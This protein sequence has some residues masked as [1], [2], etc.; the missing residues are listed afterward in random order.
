MSFAK[1][2]AQILDSSLAEDYRVRLVFEDMLKLS[3]AKGVVDMTRESIARRTN[4]PLK[5]V[6][7]S[8]KTLEDP[9]PT[10]RTPDYDGR[11][12]VRL[13]A[14]RDWG[15]RIVNFVKYR[16]SAT[17]E[18]LR[19]AEAERKKA[20]RSRHSRKPSSPI[21]PT[22][23]GTEAEGEADKSM[24]MSGTCPGHASGNGKLSTPQLIAL[25]GQVRRKSAR[26]HELQKQAPFEK[27][28]PR[29]S[30]FKQL[31]FEIPQLEKQLTRATA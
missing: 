12:I 16:E 27:Q 31:K 13:D 6:S 22:P 9:D 18:M 23:T 3:D 28:D 14:H 15:W 5:I 17:V 29:L 25:D 21:P 19:M 10:S 8:I 1:V 7:D 4:V 11:R 24:D 20:Y 30:E 2:F 26:L